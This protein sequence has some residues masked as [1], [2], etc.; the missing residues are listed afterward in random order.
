VDFVQQVMEKFLESFPRGPPPE[1]YRSHWLARALKNLVV[2]DW[3]K[4]AVRQRAMVDPSL[5]LMAAPQPVAGAAPGAP[6]PGGMERV[7]VDDLRAAVARL[8]PKLRQAYELHM[9]GLSYDDIA[10]HLR[11]TVTA[12]GKRLHDARRRLR[13]ILVQALEPVRDAEPAL[14]L[15][16]CD[17]G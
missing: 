5:Q 10:S 15:A 3:R 1:P 16:A 8:S 14:A 12:A 6:L 7:T 13:D 2:S 17:G 4:R 9:R 11:I